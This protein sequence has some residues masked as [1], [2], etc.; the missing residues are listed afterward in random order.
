MIYFTADLHLGH[1]SVISSCNRPF[2]SVGEMDEA[3][4]SNWNARVRGSDTVYILGDLVWKCDDA[5]KLISSLKGKKVLILGNHDGKLVEDS[6]ALACFQSVERYSECVIC[7][8]NFTLCHYPMTEWKNSRKT[9]S[10]RLGFHVFGHIHNR[11]D[12]ALYGHLFRTANALN[13]GTDINGFKPVTLDELIANNSA[14]RHDLLRG[15]PADDELTESERNLK[16][17]FG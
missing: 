10:R 2:S 13:A 1:K 7:S 6:A 4:I 16:R 8:R 9:T 5:A 17:L 14:F 3:L 11:T 15:T 12:V